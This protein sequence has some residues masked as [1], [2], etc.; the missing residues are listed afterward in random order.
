[1]L[2]DELEN[3]CKARFSPAWAKLFARNDFVGIALADVMSNA[4]KG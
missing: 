4:D 1:L 3:S 2:L